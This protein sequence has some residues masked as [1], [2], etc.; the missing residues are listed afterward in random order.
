MKL[1]EVGE[2]RAGYNDIDIVR[3]VHLWIEQAQLVTVIGPNGAG[4][5]T[6]LK[7]ISGVI[8]LRAGTVFLDGEDISRESVEARV[9]IGLR[10][11]PQA[12]N[13]FPSLTVLENL[14][15]GLLARGRVTRSAIRSRLDY[16]S[17][18]L[19]IL[20]PMMGRRCGLLSG[21]ERQAVA[22]GA[23]L[24]TE[25]KVLLLDEPSAGLS[26]KLASE[27]FHHIRTIANSGLGVLVVEQN[28]RRAVDAA[29]HTYVLDGGQNA[30]DGKGA[31]LLAD[32]R[33]AELYLGQ[34]GGGEGEANLEPSLHG[35]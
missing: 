23:A 21:G 27:V 33:V 16:V 18:L 35:A 25:P 9:R 31:A 19:P 11:V 7:A 10:Y 14:E 8:P 26:P 12:S 28:A 29:D 15:I 4:K 20:K 6:M 3:D 32:P 24:M 34:S 5:S 30:L 17:E 1:L 13:V 2:A 22:F